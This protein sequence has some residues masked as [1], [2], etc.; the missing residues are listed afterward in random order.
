MNTDSKWDA[1]LDRMARSN[2][3][4]ASDLVGCTQAEIAALESN[5]QVQLPRSYRRYLEL[6]G[7]QSGRLFTSDHA[8][9]FYPY[10]LNLT[11]ELLSGLSD[12]EAP[13]SFALPHGALLIN[14]RLGDQFEFIICDG[15]VEPGVSY[16]NTWDWNIVK[17]HDTVIG[18]LES[19][20][21][22]AEDAL[23][24]GY[25]DTYP[26]GTTP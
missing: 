21:D 11:S 4:R 19:W 20:C 17:S 2:V 5:Y 24:S 14:G 7:H 26:N 3:A 10:L 25:F 16:F 1:F 13:S 8:A 18:W 6:M 12:L 9:A 22:L 23:A 15:T